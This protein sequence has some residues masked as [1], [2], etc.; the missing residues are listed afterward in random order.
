MNL[1][2]GIVFHSLYHKL[3]NGIYSQGT[4]DYSKNRKAVMKLPETKVQEV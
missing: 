2:I 1:N 3:R 4:Y